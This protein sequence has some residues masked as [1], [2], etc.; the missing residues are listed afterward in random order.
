[1]IETVS[2]NKSIRFV[3][4]SPPFTIMN[5]NVFI[6]VFIIINGGNLLSKK[7]MDFFQLIVS[8]MA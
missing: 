1:M 5:T 8:I 2:W 3:S 4:I 7:H 6:I